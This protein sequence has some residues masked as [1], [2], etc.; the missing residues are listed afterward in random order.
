[1]E[2]KRPKYIEGIGWR[3]ETER[4]RFEVCA[5]GTLLILAPW[6][7][8]L[9]G[10]S[11]YERFHNLNNIAAAICRLDATTNYTLTTN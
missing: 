9:K 1:M 5:S 10:D 7:D 8:D 11:E 6:H 3:Y 4:S 2:E